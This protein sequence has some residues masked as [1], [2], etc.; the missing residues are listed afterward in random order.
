M[1]RT[2]LILCAAL[3]VGCDAYPKEWPNEGVW[4]AF[5]VGGTVTVVA[6]GRDTCVHAWTRGGWMYY[7]GV[8]QCGF[9]DREMG[10]F[11]R[12]RA[13]RLCLRLEKVRRE[14][15]PTCLADVTILRRAKAEAVFR[16]TLHRHSTV[17]DGDVA[18]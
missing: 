1:K 4:G 15:C 6:A 18:Y 16:D 13:C 8:D 2:I 12:E 11:E 3:A 17:G 7:P 9:T 5:S 14:V 10:H